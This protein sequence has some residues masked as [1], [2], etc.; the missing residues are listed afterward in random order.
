MRQKF[1]HRP[2][3][4]MVKTT[5]PKTLVEASTDKLW[6]TGISIKDNNA[7]NMERWHSVDWM[8]TILG[9]IRDKALT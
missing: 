8:S 2:I 9:K 1:V 6:G 7:L 5:H 3:L 4:E